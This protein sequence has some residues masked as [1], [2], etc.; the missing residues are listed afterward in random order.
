MPASELT[1]VVRLLPSRRSAD[2]Q[3]MLELKE[4]GTAVLGNLVQDEYGPTRAERAAALKDLIG[5]VEGV[6]LAIDALNDVARKILNVELVRLELL[7]N[8]RCFI[9]I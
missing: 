3:I 2:E 6:S 1:E 5:S 8:F 9:G 7:T 4:C